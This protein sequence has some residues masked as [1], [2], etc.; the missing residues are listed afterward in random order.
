MFFL[1]KEGNTD[2]QNI[3]AQEASEKGRARLPQEN[4]YKERPQGACKTQSQ[5]K[6]DIDLLITTN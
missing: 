5:G 1:E 3:S 2:D 4:G 6:K